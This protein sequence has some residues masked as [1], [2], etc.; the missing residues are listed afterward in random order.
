VE[1]LLGEGREQGN[2]GQMVDERITTQAG[3]G[4]NLLTVSTPRG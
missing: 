4:W 3:H 2:L 1:V